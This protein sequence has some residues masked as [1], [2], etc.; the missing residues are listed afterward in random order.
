MHKQITLIT[1]IHDHNCFKNLRRKNLKDK[2]ELQLEDTYLIL[3]LRNDQV[4]RVDC[5]L[6]TPA[7]TCVAQS[8]FSLVDTNKC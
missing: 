6:S 1:S 5:K 8:A 7:I 4:P 2:E 3:K